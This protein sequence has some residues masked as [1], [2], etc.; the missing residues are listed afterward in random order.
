MQTINILPLTSE[1]LVRK[2][3]IRAAGFDIAL[4]ISNIG[5]L[6]SCCLHLTIRTS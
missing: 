5:M 1:H 6:N 4:H 3:D 2:R